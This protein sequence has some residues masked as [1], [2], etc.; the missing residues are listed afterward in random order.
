MCVCSRVFLFEMGVGYD[1]RFV[2]KIFTL[3]LILL[4]S[5][6]AAHDIPSDLTVHALLKPAGTRMELL[7]RVPLP[8]IR[9]IAF[10]EREGGYLDVEKLAPLLPDAA[11]LWIAQPVRI[12]ENGRPLAA[13]RIA[14]T[15]ISLPSD[16][17]FA[18]F[19]TAKTHITGPP[20]QN[21]E[22]PVWNQVYFDVLLEYPIQS[23]RSRFAIH[24]AFTH[25]AARVVT[26]LRW[27]PP[28]SSVRAYEFTGDPG[29]TVLDPSWHQAALTFVKLGFLHILD[30][31]DHLLFLLCLVIPCRRVM[32]LVAVVTAFA[33]AHSITL[34]GSAFGW[35][36]AALWFP[37][38]VEVLIAASILYMALENIIRDDGGAAHRRWMLAFGFGLI[39]GFGFSFAL[40]ETLQFAG[41]HLLLSLLSFNIGV[42]LGQ[43]LVV[44][45]MTPAIA[46]LFRY[47]VAPRMGAIILSAFIAHTAWH[48]MA[49]RWEVLRKYSFEWP[50]LDSATLSS[51][52]RWMMLLVL[53]V[54]ADWLL[55]RI[56]RE[57]R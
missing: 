8:A 27:H 6:A 4:A 28:N 55:R 21:A 32:P 40:R 12:E 14:A 39:H 50:P 44:A 53:L 56:R 51:A 43:I 22:H 31:I 35:A 41:D 57:G 52:L 25:L 7:V 38:L 10:P 49:E 1:T 36:P 11:R 18:S 45:L 34:I 5:V 37:P 47:A 2:S 20:L 15:R 46:L 23:E 9:D 17:S 33:V 16:R 13:P 29:M 3:A 24:P 19:E 54:A 30:G 26:V 48:W 42:E